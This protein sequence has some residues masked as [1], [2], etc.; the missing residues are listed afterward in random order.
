MLL[1]QGQ[2]AEAEPLLAE[3]REIFARLEARPWLERAAGVEPE[4]Q[5]Q[6]PA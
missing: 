4:P 1:E 3:A 2:A 5:A 6:V